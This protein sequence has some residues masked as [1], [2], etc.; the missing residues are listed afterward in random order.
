MA[1]RSG[2]W[3]RSFGRGGRGRVRTYRHGRSFSARSG[4]ALRSRSRGRSVHGAGARR[5]F[6]ARSGHRLRSFA[7][8][9]VVRGRGGRVRSFARRYSRN[10]WSHSWGGRGRRR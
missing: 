5:S 4:R 3:T 1:A 9:R 8:G 6:S 10:V 7:R 2:R